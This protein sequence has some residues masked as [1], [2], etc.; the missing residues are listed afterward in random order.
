MITLNIIKIFILCLNSFS[1]TRRKLKRMIFQE[2]SSILVSPEF[3]EYNSHSLNFSSV[4]PIK[5]RYL[6]FTLT[7]NLSPTFDRTK[8]CRLLR[9]ARAVLNRAQRLDIRG[10]VQV[11][12]W[13]AWAV[14]GL[15]FFSR[16]RLPDKR[17]CYVATFYRALPC[18][19]REHWRLI[20]AISPSWEEGKIQKWTSLP[21]YDK[22][23]VEA[24]L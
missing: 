7:V 18:L 12:L 3:P 6:G 14:A 2:I 21:N 23:N 9:T 4:F 8:L 19:L 22:V 24:S 16:G 5:V 13:C 10:T 11:R 17:S 1:I 15:V 20:N